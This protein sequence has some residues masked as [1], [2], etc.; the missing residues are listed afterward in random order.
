M[1]VLAML[2]LLAG[3]VLVNLPWFRSAGGPRALAEELAGKLEQLRG[4]ARAGQTTTAMAWLPN[5]GGLARSCLLLE[6][7]QRANPRQTFAWDRQYPDLS[8][9]A[10]ALQGL[11]SQSDPPQA[12]DAWAGPYQNL[13]LL[14]FRPDGQ[15]VGLNL[16]RV[17]GSYRL[18][19]GDGLQAG[20]QLTAVHRGVQIQIPASG[21]PRIEPVTLGTLDHPLQAPPPTAPPSSPPT[22]PLQLT[23]VLLTPPQNPDA[24]GADQARVEPE[25]YL[26][27]TVHARGSDYEPLTC[28][29]TVSGGAR[30]SVEACQMLWNGTAFESTWEWQAPPDST[31]DQTYLLSCQV[32]NRRGDLATAL[33]NANV[34]VRIIRHGSVLFSSDRDGPIDLYKVNED[35]SR[36]RRLTWDADGEQRPKFSP[37]SS[38]IV[39][40]KGNDLWLCN[41]DGS[42][43]RRLTN[44]GSAQ[45]AEPTWNALGTQIAYVEHGS[46]GDRIMRIN[47]D[48]DNLDPTELL[49]GYAAGQLGFVDWA[50]D[51]SRLLLDINNSGAT[52]LYEFILA[53]HSLNILRSVHTNNEN[54]AHFSPDGSRIVYVHRNGAKKEVWTSTF[55]VAVPNGPASISSGSKEVYD[56]EWNSDPAWGPDGARIVFGSRRPSETAA[57]E[58]LWQ[59]TTGS[60][61][62]PRKLSLKN[63]H[64]WDPTWGR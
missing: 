62:P 9:F 35:G 16:P 39:F 15:A 44:L 31:V 28:T 11:P 41:A 7:R 46:G 20:A 23:E 8:G 59:I 37:D 14:A 38:R 24:L 32:R 13:P 42:Q 56:T 22:Q 18:V 47:A 36:L 29:W 40:P 60:S 33:V 2:A 5:A 63:L 51:N 30:S 27:L 45:A 54:H 21:V 17:E 48:E 52:D 53:S 34:Q 19:I 6:G 64:D 26:H 50:P 43:A 25:A 58:R 49:G 57:D 4:R 1:V 3:M 55:S 61:A 10:G 12:I